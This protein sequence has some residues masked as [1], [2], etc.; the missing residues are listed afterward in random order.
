[1]NQWITPLA[2]QGSQFQPLDTGLTV[3]GNP[4]L[5]GQAVSSVVSPDGNTLLVLTSGY[6]RIYN[7]NSSTPSFVSNTGMPESTEYVFIYDIPTGTPVQK[8]VVTIPNS[9][10]G[11]A[12]DPFQPLNNAFYVS[13]GMGDF[14]FDS[15]GHLDPNNPQFDNVHIFTLSVD[16][17]T[18]AQQQELL[19]NHPA[20]A[21]A[22]PCLTRDQSR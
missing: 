16:G 19:L 20:G 11:I 15:A 14:P 5:A 6:N 22:F 7:T 2:P 8:Q 1:M 10:N 18:W 21:L 13:S 4:W 3:N 9:Y 12:F 17:T